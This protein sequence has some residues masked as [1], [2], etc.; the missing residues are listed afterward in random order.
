MN[1]SGH[2]NN[3]NH[4]DSWFVIN[5]FNHILEQVI[6]EVFIELEEEVES[7]LLVVHHFLSHHCEIVAIAVLEK[8][9]V[10][11]GSVGAW[12]EVFAFVGALPFLFGHNFF[13]LVIDIVDWGGEDL[14]V[15]EAVGPEHRVVPHVVAV[16]EI[17]VMVLVEEEV[18]LSNGSCLGIN[19]EIVVNDSCLVDSIQFC[20]V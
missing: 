10:N 9:V 2:T 8:A 4:E 5:H 14:S 18:G 19:Y 17:V 1:I 11:H 15:L 13:S 3:E 16:D 12:E 20:F 7:K 6:V